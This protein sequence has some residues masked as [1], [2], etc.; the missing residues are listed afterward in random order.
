[1]RVESMIGAMLG[2]GVASAL[3]GDQAEAIKQFTAALKIEPADAR[4]LHNRAQAYRA[5]VS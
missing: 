4:T 1:M 3:E 2:A 5:C